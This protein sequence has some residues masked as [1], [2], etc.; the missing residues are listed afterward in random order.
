MDPDTIGRLI[1]TVLA[2]CVSVWLLIRAANLTP[3]SRQV[4]SAALACGVGVFPI[5]GAATFARG[6]GGSILLPALGVLA[7]G[8][9]V[10]G[11]VLA[12][13]ALRARAS[14][15][16]AGIA[17]PVVAVLL[18][19]LTGC[20][21]G[22]LILFPLLN[23]PLGPAWS[24][25]VAAHGFELT[26]PSGSWRQADASKELARFGCPNP[27]MVSS[28]KEVRPAPTETGFD[29][30]IA[31]LR[32]LIRR[33][34]ST[35][36]EDRRGVNAHGHAYWVY[37]GEEDGPGGKVLVALSVTWWRKEKAVVVIF[38]GH[39]RMLSQVARQQETQRFR[40]DAESVLTSVK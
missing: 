29:A 31:D 24:Y 22:G 11:L 30:A 40:A 4:S 27:P 21:G 6:E 20:A 2:G 38:E 12:V 15:H 19:G 3:R 10:T 28:V 26:L 1:P 7:L 5:T 34:P 36:L 17:G 33:H 37:V 39:H 14:D 9:A 25:Q 32:E 16:G 18:S 13:W 23:R 35:P 8:V